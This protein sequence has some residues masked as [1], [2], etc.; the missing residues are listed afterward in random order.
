MRGA[1][2]WVISKGRRDVSGPRRAVITGVSAA[3]G[4]DDGFWEYDGK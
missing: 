2:E 3:R 1:D 4:M